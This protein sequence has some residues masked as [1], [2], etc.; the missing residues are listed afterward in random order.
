MADA[1]TDRK[2][3]PA[4]SKYATLPP[5]NRAVLEWLEEYTSKPLSADADEYWREMGE[6]VESHPF[7]FRRECDDETSTGS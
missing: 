6:F 1:D 7:T 4:G 5:E 2:G 3:Q